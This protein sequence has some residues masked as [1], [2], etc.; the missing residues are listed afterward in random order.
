MPDNDIG[1]R[2]NQAT[3]TVTLRDGESGGTW[4]NN[5]GMFFPGCG[6][7]ALFLMGA[8]GRVLEFGVLFRPG[9][10]VLTMAL[11]GVP[12]VSLEQQD[13]AVLAYRLTYLGKTSI[14]QL[15]KQ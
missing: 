4:Q 9:V 1:P 6:D 2:G 14:G 15:A 13:G 3:F 5:V 11:K 12:T 8:H 10:C 7:G